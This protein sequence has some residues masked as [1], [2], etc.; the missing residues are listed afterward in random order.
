[1]KKSI[2]TTIFFAVACL[3]LY[4][5]CKDEKAFS[6][7]YDINFPVSEITG[8][9][10]KTALVGTE[11][12][13]HGANLDMVTTLSVGSI[14]CEVISQ[15]PGELVFKVSRSAEQGA[16]VLMNKFKRQST[17][18]EP[19][20]PQ[21]LDMA[22]SS[23]P[24]EIERGMTFNITG[25][26][27]DM[28]ESVKFENATLRKVSASETTATYSTADV[29][30]PASGMLTVTS[31]TGQLFT[32]PVLEVVEPKDTYTPAQSILLFDFDT[33]DPTIVAGDA[34]GFT[35]GK[36]LSGI[37]PFFGNY[38][39]I[40]AANGNGW[41]GNY[42]LL[43]TTNNGEGFNLATFKDPHL[44]FLVNTNGKQGYMN[45]ALTIG[46]STT[47]QHFTGQG[48][49]YTDSYMI[50]TS[51]WEWRSYSLE[52]M[53]F[54]GVRGE[55]EKFAFLV[56]G[57]NVDE[58]Q[59]FE[60]HIDQV[61]FTDGPLNPVVVFDFETMPPFSGGTASLN[62]GSGVQVVPQGKSYLTVKDGNVSSWGNKGSI[63]RKENSGT[64]FIVNQGFY[65]NFLI[66]TGT[67][68]KGYFQL[69][70]EQGEET[71]LG[72]HFAGDNPYGD[73]YMFDNTAGQ[74]QWRSVR[75]DPKG[76]ENWGSNPELDLSTP[77]DLTI[78]FSTGN[79]EGA[80]E[81]NLD[82]VVLTSVPLDCSN[83]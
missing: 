70:F 60:I 61:M 39:S 41:N 45:P 21:Y 7:D 16:I 3:F 20:I 28:I 74:W 71:E 78:D 2:Y 35:S 54:N 19:F 52:E 48:G 13:I 46:G 47:D 30:L 55:I 40:T 31:K 67:T 51:G 83:R 18:D 42:Q 29:T 6:E 76:L 36:N 59:P 44:T 12:T 8:F 25:T 50:A 15:A 62:Q 5:G 10:P 68:G 66:N 73:N 63:T 37:T 4:T 11:V 26:N 72:K 22:V 57:G 1:M 14:S 80:Y 69:I 75:I 79:V 82:Y 43:E 33:L 53:G 24:T 34:G 49:E 81:V 17:S 32:S 56:R 38:Y 77:F 65:I 64:R 23:W 58:S 27:V 9:T